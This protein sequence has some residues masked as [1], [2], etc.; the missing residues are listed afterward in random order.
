[1]GWPEIRFKYLVISL[2]SKDMC[3]KTNKWNLNKNL[4]NAI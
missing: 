3:L 4:F 2:V 1:M